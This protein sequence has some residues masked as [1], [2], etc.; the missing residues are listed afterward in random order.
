[1]PPRDNWTPE[2]IKRMLALLHE[3]LSASVISE[4]LGGVSRS[5]VIGKLYRMGYSVS[6]PA[7]KGVGTDVLAHRFQAKRAA[8]D[9]ARRM[10]AKLDIHPIPAPK[11]DD[12]A[13]LS[14][15]QLDD[16]CAPKLCR[17]IPGDPAGKGPREAQFC[18]LETIPGKP[19]C[20]GHLARAYTAPAPRRN[21][22]VVREREREPA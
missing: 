14:F 7:Y 12:V 2:R 4:D 22:Q 20:P 18:G 6:S 15:L 9:F 17:W 8:R 13:R 3:G 11:A 1:M 10:R 16:S 5:A 21:P 19:Y